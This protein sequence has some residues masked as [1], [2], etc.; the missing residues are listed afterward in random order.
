VCVC[1]CVCVVFF[2]NSGVGMVW[3]CSGVHIC[4]QHGTVFTMAWCA[5]A[6]HHVHGFLAG[7]TEA[8]VAWLQEMDAHLKANDPEVDLLSLFRTAD[9]LSPAESSLHTAVRDELMAAMESVNRIR[10]AGKMVK[11]MDGCALG[12]SVATELE[13]ASLVMVKA[14]E[15]LVTLPEDVQVKI[16][17]AAKGRVAAKVKEMQ[18][19]FTVSYK[20]R[21]F[22]VWLLS[23][24]IVFTS[25]RK[26]VKLRLST[27]L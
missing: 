9:N 12:E 14:K 24:R 17:K 27:Y 25:V 15:K 11:G 8:Q 26:R 23:V 1:V 13:A 3:L 6:I 21:S 22:Q 20:G 16:V 18:T 7:S 4:A 2:Y 10:Q 19:T 5:A